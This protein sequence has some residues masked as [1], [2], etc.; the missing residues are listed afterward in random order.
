MKSGGRLAC[1]LGAAFFLT[2]NF[3]ARAA[4]DALAWPPITAQTKPWAFNWW[5]GSAVDKTNLTRELERYQAAGLGGIHI[6]PIYGAKGFESKYINYLSPEWME[7]MGWAVSEAHRL[8]MDVDMTTGSGWC[9]GGPQVTDQDA[10]ANVVVKTYGL[11]VGERLKE[12]F[13]RDS[14]QALV[15]FGPDGKSIELTDSITT[16][17]E[18]F[19]SPPGNWAGTNAPPK[20]W[21]VYAISQKPSGQKVK[22]AG[23][24]GE[25]WMLNLI[26]PPAMDDFLKPY[27]AAFANYHGPKP[28]AQYHDS[29]EYRSDWSPS[30]FA[31]FEK[32]RGYKL[33]TELP[34]LFGT[35]TD[36]HAARV[37]CDYRQTV[38]EIMAEESLPK[39]TQWSHDHG[40]L[41]RNQAHGSPGNWL[42]LYAA[43]DIPETEMFHSDRNKLISKFASSAAHVTGKPLVS[44][45]TG[46]WLE[47]HFTEKL[48]DVKYLF[49]DLFLSGINHMFYHG[50]CY[51]PDEAGWPG[52][53]FYASLEM[54]PRNSIWHDAYAVNAYA[55]RCQSI[56]QSGA[57]DN[58]ILLYWPIEDF[59]MQPGDKLLPQ[60]TVHARDWFEGQPIGRTAKELWDRGYAFDYVSDAQLKTAKVVGKEIQM[61][62]GKYQVIVVPECKFIPLETFK[63]LLALA[64]N[65]ATVIFEK[66]TLL[67]VSGANDLDKARVQLK[68]LKSKL[69]PVWDE[70]QSPTGIQSYQIGTGCI[71]T[72]LFTNGTKSLEYKNKAVC[73][74][75]VGVGLSFVRRSFDGGWN[76]FIANRG[77]TNFDGWVTIGRDAKSIVILDPMTG[78]SGVAATRQSA[79]NST[80]A[81]LQLAAGESVILRAFAD[82]KVEVPA[83]NYWQTNGQPVEITGPWNV[84]FLLGGPT[85]PA[86]FQTAKLASWTTF[87]DTNTQAFAGTAKYAITF[88]APG[89]E[90]RLQAARVNAELQTYSLDLGDVR[91]SARVRVNGKD[92][93]TLITPPFRMVV[94]NLKPT[95]N[96]LEVE[97]TSV[98]ANR[99]RDLDRRGVPWKTFRDI[100]IVDL[101]YKPFDASNWPLTDC[102]LLGPVT[103]TSVTPIKN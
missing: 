63:Q 17:G 12:K 18:V 89:S 82:K 48:S 42:D 46:T 102:G 83:W 96:Q 16:N 35:N 8:G 70:N 90:S 56:L 5:M 84:K 25:G 67:D 65:G 31:E 60:F 87:P 72:G 10:N 19:F 101:N 81:H 32:R 85:L 98:A 3:S 74:S 55:A 44:S 39:W 47:E 15:A 50:C 23:P 77:T 30:F 58:D 4:D 75:L 62:G 88:D 38:S 40:F 97:V 92:Y 51:S 2:I 59:W 11:G 80:E 95:G 43:A 7:M 73:E 61:P 53:H 52:W 91:Q 21:T 14:I 26:Y 54:N 99:I 6:I 86:D 36:D 93:G 103:L 29:Y 37:K 13:N 49:D 78:N 33:Q 27:T 69:V 76:Y 79:A 28:R 34:A 100:N 94:D 1:A 66:Q 57:P 20:T 22:R 71:Y 45:E 68:F 64:K 41:T 9:F 24:G